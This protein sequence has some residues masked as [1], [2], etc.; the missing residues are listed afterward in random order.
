MADLLLVSDGYATVEKF[1]NSSR[2]TPVHICKSAESFKPPCV[3]CVERVM[4]IPN[5]MKTR[6]AFHASNF[7]SSRTGGITETS[8]LEALKAVAAG[9]DR[10]SIDGDV[11]TPNGDIIA[12]VAYRN[13]L[14]ELERHINAVDGVHS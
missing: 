5:F 11:M 8:L 6:A 1:H 3:T 9:I 12:V 13:F 2:N 4:N 7:S 14:A 10:L